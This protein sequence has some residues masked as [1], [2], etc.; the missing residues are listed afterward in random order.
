MRIGYFLTS[1]EFRCLGA[2]LRR[3][4]GGLTMRGGY[5][6][7][8]VLLLA[9]V[10]AACGAPTGDEPYRITVILGQQ[11]SMFSTSLA[12]GARSAA[13]TAGA[14]FNL[15]APQNWDPRE[16]AALV[17]SVVA[18]PPD[19]VLIAPVDDTAMIG[20]MRAMRRAGITLVEVNTRVTDRAL[21]AAH[22]ASDNAKAGRL[23]A[24]EM[25]RR[26]SDKGA[27]LILG[28]EPATPTTETRAGAFAE[29]VRRNHP[30]LTVLYV[31]HTGDEQEKARQIVADTVAEHPDLVGVFS[32]DGITA[33]GAAEALRT[34][35]R[36][37][38]VIHVG[39]D[40]SPKEVEQLE[41]GGV[42]V[43]IAQEPYLM[44]EDGVREAVRAL[45]GEEVQERV[46]TGLSTISRE[47]LERR[48]DLVYA[49]HDC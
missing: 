8:A 14:E 19:A 29:E 11:G 5:R 34:A 6:L 4:H 17:R 28:V 21:A 7:A 39:M 1:E 43:L 13:D 49:T 27:V 25:T 33:L 44:G 36:A 46:L 20:P 10:T 23:A 18:D 45:D 32:T 42:D 24:D 22:V 2:G 37:R 9:A 16:Q 41:K 15:V 12:C 30:G 31:R 48:H 26:M 40:A 38:D 47:T 3:T 35:G